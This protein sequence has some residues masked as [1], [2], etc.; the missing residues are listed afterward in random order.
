MG[1]SGHVVRA[2]TRRALPS[3]KKA[4]FYPKG[5]GKAGEYHDLIYIST[6][7]P[8]CLVGDRVGRSK[9]ETVY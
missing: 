8:G 2:G 9:W 5:S 3:I 7:Y 1:I 6:V 4:C